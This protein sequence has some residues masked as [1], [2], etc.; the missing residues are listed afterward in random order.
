M[1]HI[2]SFCSLLCGTAFRCSKKLY[3]KLHSAHWL[4]FMGYLGLDYP[5]PLRAKQYFFDLRLQYSV[6]ELAFEDYDLSPSAFFSSVL[7]EQA[8]RHGLLG[9]CRRSFVRGDRFWQGFQ[10]FCSTQ[11]FR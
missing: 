5:A 8:G 9:K 11:R 2:S 3:V 1:E 7:F 4:D 6:P 10:L